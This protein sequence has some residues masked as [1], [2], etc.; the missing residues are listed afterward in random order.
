MLVE[1][2]A[3]GKS[4]L[5]GRPIVILA[6]RDKEDMEEELES[7]GIEM[8]GSTVSCRGGDPLMRAEQMK[9]SAQYARCAPLHPGWGSPSSMQD[10]SG[11]E[12]GRCRRRMQSSSPHRV[13]PSW[14][15]EV[16][17]A[18]VVYGL[19]LTTLLPLSPFPLHPL[20]IAAL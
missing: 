17:R 5:G 10:V 14:L 8:R 12:G 19:W 6:E 15:K 20:P 18:S 1:K 3:E 4:S 7:H 9:V 2:L 16:S 11:E 13:M